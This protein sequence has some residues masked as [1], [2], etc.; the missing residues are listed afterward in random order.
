MR[1]P[2]GHK[3]WDGGYSEQDRYPGPCGALSFRSFGP[4]P[5]NDESSN[6]DPQPRYEPQMDG[7]PSALQLNNPPNEQKHSG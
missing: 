1:L 2:R 4:S 7:L 5:P 6:S 3:E